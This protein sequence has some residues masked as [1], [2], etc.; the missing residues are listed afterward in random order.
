MKKQLPLAKPLISY[1]PVVS[2]L[3]GIMATNMKKYEC[4]IYNNFIDIILENAVDYLNVKNW[5]Q[6]NIFEFLK[7]PRGIIYTLDKNKIIDMICKWIDE[8]YYILVAFETFYLSKYITYKQNKFRHY[9]MISGYDR[10]KK[11]FF[12]SDFF[13]FTFYRVEECMMDEVVE[14]IKNNGSPTTKGAAKDFTLLRIDHDIV[15]KLDINKIIMSLNMLLMDNNKNV[16]RQYGLAIFD[17]IYKL[18]EKGNIGEDETVFKRHAQFIVEHMKIM[19]MRAQYI[20]NLTKDGQLDCVIT[21]MMQEEIKVQQYRNYVLKLLI[22]DTKIFPT[23]KR[24]MYIDFLK[25]IKRTYMN[26]IAILKN[27]LKEIPL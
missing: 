26:N 17:S 16:Q 9:A 14:A 22:T 8:Q 18:I 5:Y 21:S 10:N 7:I 4:C 25:N 13:D 20:Q 2:H 15:L 1:E 3:T 11:I 23:A 6:Y 27:Y 19:R 12:C 24:N